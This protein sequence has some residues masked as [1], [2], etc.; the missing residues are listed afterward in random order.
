VS[1]GASAFVLLIFLS[2]RRAFRE[3]LRQG[4]EKQ[5]ENDYGVDAFLSCLFVGYVGNLP[6]MHPELEGLWQPVYAEFDGEEAPKMM[7]EKMEIELVGGEYAVRFGGVT[8]DQGTYVVDAGGL[9]L[10]GVT[11]PNAGRTIPCLCKFAGGALSICYGL[12]GTR[13]EKF[14]T[15]AGQQLYLVNYQRKG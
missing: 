13:P 12:N 6:F 1:H 11:G 14:T 10:R 7:L 3:Y 2:P 9:T 15:A 8:A 4:N 5:K